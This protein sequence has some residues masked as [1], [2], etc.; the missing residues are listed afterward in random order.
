MRDQFILF[1]KLQ[2]DL[3]LASMPAFRSFSSGSSVQVSTQHIN[4]VIN[5]SLCVDVQTNRGLS[6]SSAAA[7]GRCLR[8]QRGGGGQGC[9][10]CANFADGGTMRA[11]Q[12][13]ESLNIHRHCPVSTRNDNT[14]T[15]RKLH[16]IGSRRE[17]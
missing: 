4:T 2:Q 7:L 8:T 15:W 14:T 9:A 5:L 3:A 12:R 10:F 16:V 17:S 1:C 6:A 11:R 13:W